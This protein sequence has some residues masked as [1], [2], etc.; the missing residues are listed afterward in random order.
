MSQYTVHA[1]DHSTDLGCVGRAATLREARALGRHQVDGCLPGGC[2][3]YTVRD[4][5]GQTI[6]R[7]ERTLRTGYRWRVAT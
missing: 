2:G 7:G 3:I 5:S 4:A 6:E 1:G